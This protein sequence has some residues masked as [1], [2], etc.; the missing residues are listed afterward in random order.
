MP[1]TISN[2]SIG[3]S[4][5]TGGLSA[6]LD[7][8]QSRLLKFKRGNGAL[9]DLGKTFDAIAT[10]VKTLGVDGLSEFE[11][12]LNSLKAAGTSDHTL[13]G[14]LQVRKVMDDLKSRVDA[15]GA[16]KP[17][18]LETKIADLRLLGATD[19]ELVQIKG[20]LDAITNFQGF[21]KAGGILA[22]F[23]DQVKDLGI[24]QAEKELRNF[25]AITGVTQGQIADFKKL[26][27]QV[28]EFTT[29]QAN[30][31]KVSGTLGTL[32]A[33]SARAGLSPRSIQLLDLKEA[34]ASNAQLAQAKRHLDDIAAK[35]AFAKHRDQ[36]AQLKTQIRQS[37]MSELQK[38]LDT[39]SRMR[40]L[41]KNQVEELKALT[42]ELHRV[43]ESADQPLTPPKKGGLFGALVAKEV[44]DQGVNAARYA[45]AQ[46]GAAL[47]R[48][49]DTGKTAQ[50][51]N[52][53]TETFIAFGLAAKK[54]GLDTDASAKALQKM[55][56]NIG[57]ARAGG[58]EQ[59]KAFQALGLSLKDINTLG[60][61]DIL[62]RVVEGIKNTGNT[63]SRAA[64]A[65]K[66]FGDSGAGIGFA[67]RDGAKAMDEAMEKARK[68]G[69]LFSAVD[70]KM[71]SDASKAMKEVQEVIDG[72]WT[73]IAVELAPAIS[74]V[75]D[76]FKSWVEDSGIKNI[77]QDLAN[78]TTWVFLLKN[79]VQAVKDAFETVSIIVRGIGYGL[80]GLFEVV[81]RAAAA[82]LDAIGQHS[83]TL[84]GVVD[85]LT[86][87][88]QAFGEAIGQN[89]EAIQKGQ[90]VSLSEAESFVKAQRDKAAAAVAAQGSLGQAY[91]AQAAKSNEVKQKVA[92]EIAQIEQAIFAVNAS[93]IEIKVKEL[94]GL[95]ANSEQIEQVKTKMAELAKAEAFKAIEAQIKSAT[96]AVADFG[97]T[98]SQLALARA[99]AGGANDTQLT[100]LKAQ[101]SALDA[102]KKAEQE[103][104]DA[105]KAFADDQSKAKDLIESLKTPLDVFNDKLEEVNRLQKAGLLNLTQADAITKRL[106]DDLDKQLADKKIDGNVA[107][108]P[109]AFTI[110]SA[111]QQRLQFQLGNQSNNPAI[112]IARQQLNAQQAGNKKLGIIAEKL[113][114]AQLYAYTLN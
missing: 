17:P 48:I 36:V 101:L 56:E 60:E 80:V 85:G 43:R 10:K 6:G 40:G 39:I 104:A 98:E 13:S 61:K 53:P 63:S 58:G 86:A 52:L 91:D 5:N 9:N 49:Q 107:A 19:A 16:V 38:Q 99:Q 67:F 32:S 33:Q 37:G 74:M 106:G 81:F 103:R 79:S 22:K 72:V 78:A 112:A 2:I 20:H 42:V 50:R 1:T 71:A 45:A 12:Q 89:V 35:T 46:V 110:G 69:A 68:S 87:T 105:A 57:R 65:V 108:A 93:K 111:E 62:A 70:A 82:G 96:Q 15:L 25:G 7:R 90:Y 100:A 95:G 66:V 59:V 114:P 4:L 73:K 27:A 76:L 3:L 109:K 18:Q 26:Q 31:A 83:D 29:A 94:Q 34:G 55:E 41:T 14:L 75:T 8:A 54:A 92:D 77:N 28:V 64:A 44:L 102:L 30:A 11:K 51:L 97:K 88:R 21:Q 113:Q 24:S 23:G 47:D 84:S